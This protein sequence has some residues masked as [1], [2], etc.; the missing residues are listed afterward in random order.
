MAFRHSQQPRHPALIIAEA[1]P[2]PAISH[3]VTNNKAD[4]AI[5]FTASHNPPEYNGF[6][7]PRL[8]GRPRYR[9]QPRNRGRNC[10]RSMP[11]RG[12]QADRRPSRSPKSQAAYVARLQE[13]IDLDAIRKARVSCCFRS[14]VGAARGY[15][16]TIPREAGVD[17]TVPTTAMC[18]LQ[19][20]AEPDDELLEDL[21]VEMRR[22][23]A[24]IGNRY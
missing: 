17:A 5:N 4:G 8:M 20:R 7:S 23:K 12:A 16:D 15:S 14:H 21:R 18:F 11:D 2:T 13:A 3:A 10:C 19:P 9:R 1:A 6:S 22:I 24:H